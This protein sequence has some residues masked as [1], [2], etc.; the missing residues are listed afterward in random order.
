MIAIDDPPS[1]RA[2]AVGERRRALGRRGE[3]HAAAHLRRIGYEVIAR[4]VRTCRGEIDLIV[5]DERALVFVE[6]KTRMIGDAQRAPRPD[7]H[8]LAGLGLGQRARLR[9]LAAAWLAEERSRPFAASIRFDAVGVV[10]DASGR[11]RGLEHLE[12]AW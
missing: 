12:N 11:L 10:L 8:P 5:R 3:Q 1:A 2:R 9:R 4:N 6:V 7:Q